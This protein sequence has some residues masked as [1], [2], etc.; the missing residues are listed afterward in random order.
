MFHYFLSLTITMLNSEVVL[1][2][3]PRV[4]FCFLFLYI[5]GNFVIFKIQWLSKMSISVSLGSEFLIIMCI[6]SA[7]KPCSFIFIWT[8]ILKLLYTHTYLAQYF[9]YFSLLSTSFYYSLWKLSWNSHIHKFTLK[10]SF[11]LS[12]SLFPQL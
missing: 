12:F 3:S 7:C 10:V 2:F 11:S 6:H 5:P 8:T 1:Y 9:F 4:F